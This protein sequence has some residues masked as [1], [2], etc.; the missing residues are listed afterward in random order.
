MIIVINDGEE[1]LKFYFKG[2]VEK[3]LELCILV[4]GMLGELKEF[5]KDDVENLLRDLIEFW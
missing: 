4:V 2:D 1:G 5:I 3:L